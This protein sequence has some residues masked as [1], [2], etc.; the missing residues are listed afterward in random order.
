[1]KPDQS[2]GPPTL[3][4]L[5]RV[6][7]AIGLFFI[8]PLV[9]EFL[10]GDLPITMLGA[11]VLLAPFYGGGALV[12]RE[13]VRRTGRGWPSIFVLAFSYAVL[14]EA[15]T[16]QTLFNPNYLGLNLHLLESAYIP[17]LGMGVWWTIF[18]LTLHTVWSISTSIGLAESLVPERATRPWLGRVG[19]GVVSILFVLAAVESTR[20][21]IEHDRNHFVAS[22][23]QFLSA[24]IICLLAIVT[25]FLLPK[26]R[27]SAGASGYVPGPWLVGCVALAAG[28]IFLLIPDKWGWLAVALYLILDVAVIALIVHWSHRLGW[29]SRH[30]LALAGGAA[31]AYGWHAFIQNPVVGNAGIINRIGNGLFVLG[32]GIILAIAS[33]RT[34][35]WEERSELQ[36]ESLAT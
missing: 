26:R 16:T 28:S 14:E 17:A 7:P 30:R 10:L 18:V 31:L 2:F 22:K 32:L 29:N 35:A 20:Y 9:A 24:A 15:F 8:A 6:A 23:A 1:V 4:L 12:I 21:A 11:L 27:V 19:L 25:A 34:N 3:P 5:R 36:P 13:V 33:R